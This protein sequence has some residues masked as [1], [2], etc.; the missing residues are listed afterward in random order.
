MTQSHLTPGT[1]IN[2]IDLVLY[3]DGLKLVFSDSPDGNHRTAEHVGSYYMTTNTA[4]TLRNMLNRVYPPEPNNV[5]EDTREKVWEG[6]DE[7]P[8]LDAGREEW[9]HPTT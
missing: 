7:K 1:M 8:E 6:S 9:V 5:A 2:L 3:A 4:L